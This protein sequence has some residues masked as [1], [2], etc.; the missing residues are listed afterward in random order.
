MKVLYVDTS[1]LGSIILGE[2]N[3]SKLHQLLE[4]SAN[5]MSS[6]LIEAETF[7]I[8][9]RE[10]IS[11]SVVQEYLHF[12]KFIQPDRSLRGEFEEIFSH[13]YVR[14]A[15]AM[16]LACALYLDPSRQAL[17]FYSVDKKQITIAKKL[18][19]SLPQN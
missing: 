8:A 1:I 7:T 16:H 5:V 3:A 4:R 2:K 17:Q 14:G 13:G 9:S 18:G 15:D 6:H 19:F 11:F 10:G 12:F